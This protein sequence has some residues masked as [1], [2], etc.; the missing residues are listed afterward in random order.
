[1]MFREEVNSVYCEYYTNHIYMM[2]DKMYCFVVLQQMV[3]VLPLMF[4]RL[5]R[6]GIITC[7]QKN[8]IVEVMDDHT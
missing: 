3:T 4:Q 6:G 2:C 8:E 7:I 1:M 5:I